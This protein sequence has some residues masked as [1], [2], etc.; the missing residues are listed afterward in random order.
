MWSVFLALFSFIKN[1]VDVLIFYFFFFCSKT[2]FLIF[3]LDFNLIHFYLL[4]Q[5]PRWYFFVMPTFHESI[6]AARYV[7]RLGFFYGDCHFSRL[8]LMYVHTSRKASLH[9]K[10]RLVKSPHYH[11]RCRLSGLKKFN[12]DILFLVMPFCLRF[13][14][15]HLGFNKWSLKKRSGGGGNYLIGFISF[16]KIALHLKQFCLLVNY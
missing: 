16:W 9:C 12:F 4:W 11:F 7:G 14:V 1:C 13:F 5:N 8:R 3:F 6:L 2:Y 10:N 15:S